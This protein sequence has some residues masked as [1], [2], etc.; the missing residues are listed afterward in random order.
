MSINI[1][2]DI[3]RQKWFFGVRVDESMFFITSAFLNRNALMKQYG[4][5]GTI[6]EIWVASGR[7]LPVRIFNLAD[8]KRFHARSLKCALRDNGIINKYI[9]QDDAL[10]PKMRAAA[11]A[12]DFEEFR[13]VYGRHSALFL[14]IFSLGKV[15]RENTEKFSGAL[16]RRALAEHDRW[17]NAQALPEEK[18]GE[19]LF[20]S[21]R[22]LIRRLNIKISAKDIMKYF[23]VEEVIKIKRGEITAREA[24]RIVAQ[25]KAGKRIF[26]CLNGREAEVIS[27][28]K[29]VPGIV[30]FLDILMVAENK[31]Y[32]M[33][34]NQVFGAPAFRGR[35]RGQVVLARN[36]RELARKT[37]KINGRVLV[38]VQT[39]PHFIP[40]LR[41]VK[42]II[43][44]EGGITCHAAI[45]SREFKIPCITGTKIA[46]Q[47]LKDGDE[48][49]VD[50]TRGSVTVIRKAK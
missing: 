35:V 34:D 31:K 19:M 39:T 13:K 24:R 49:E 32:Q 15:M 40:Y 41:G 11:R 23:T 45:V 50:A 38:A 29:V 42:A 21:I 16:A 2:R 44:D 5:P 26:V 3:K 6:G 37:N 43:T 46:T 25:G 48:V 7:V 27:N 8:A 36:A 14:I 1:S 30:K 12:G 47:V 17:R 20:K 4:W 18:L 9:K 33:K 28:K 10:W 22:R